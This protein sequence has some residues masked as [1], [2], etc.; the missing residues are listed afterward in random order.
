MVAMVQ[1]R[2][3]HKQSFTHGPFEAG[4][5]TMPPSA[6]TPISASSTHFSLHHPI[7]LM[8]LRP[9][10]WLAL[11]TLIEFVVV[12]YLIWALFYLIYLWMCGAVW[13]VKGLRDLVGRRKGGNKWRGE[14]RMEKTKDKV[15]GTNQEH[16]TPRFQEICVNGV[17]DKDKKTSKDTGTHGDNTGR[18]RRK[19]L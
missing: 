17:K 7:K 2:C 16:S 3:I 8:T 15:T 6:P 4:S 9:N 13:T 5:Y 14:R 1:A 18:G 12:S 10:A 11:E 19:T